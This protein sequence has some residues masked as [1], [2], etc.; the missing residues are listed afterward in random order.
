MSEFEKNERNTVKRQPLRGKYDRE[1]IFAILD[2]AFLCHVGF[3]VD[4]Q[5]FVIPTL[6]GR[7]GETI[8]IHGSAV[9]RMLTNI[10]QGP[11]ICLTVSILD[12]LVLARSAFHHSMNYRSV[13]VFGRGKLVEE[14]SE[15]LKA[16]EV[17]SE[18]VLAGRW[19]EAR[20][21]T[22][23]EMDAT[24]VIAVGIEDAAAKIRE[25]AP[26]DDK[27][28]YELGIWAGVVPIS[29]EYGDPVRDEL[30]PDGIK[31]PFSVKDLYD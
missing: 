1:T 13:T 6:Y 2:S 9:S 21:P 7:E 17:I 11:E 30:M 3:A 18:N 5:T 26:K 4:G 25:G 22:K 12:G 8:Y 27:R 19:V 24:S 14:E 15:K 10:S 28:D 31:T 20:K 23:Q 16:L 29:L